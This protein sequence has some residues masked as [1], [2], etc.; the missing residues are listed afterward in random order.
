MSRVSVR[1]WCAAVGCGLLIV[2]AGAWAQEKIKITRLDE[3]PQHT[4]PVQGTVSEL[5]S[6]REAVLGLGEK[7]RADIEADLA[8]YEINDAATLQNLY[9]RL[10]NVELLNGQYDRALLRIEQ[11]RGLED[12]EAAKLTT[13]LTTLAMIEA[14]RAADPQTDFAAY[15]QA[16]KKN[17]AAR[18]AKLPY[19]IVQDELQET[20]GRMEIFSENF[21][22]GIVKAQM[23]PVVAKTGELSADMAGSVLG[24]HYLLTER[25]PV[26]DEIVAVLQA[27]ID[28]HKIEK[29]DI[30]AA[31]DVVLT[32][33]DKAQ[34]VLV[35]VWDSGVDP[36]IFKDQL[37]VNPKEQ[38][39]GQDDDANGFID[40]VHGVA[41]DMHAQRTTGEL[42]DLGAAAARMDQAMRH[43]KG[44][45]DVQAAVDS[46]EAA[47]LKTH[48]GGLKPEDVQRFIE[49][50]SLAG[51]YAH[52]THVAGIMVAGNPFARILI[53]RHTY[54]H[55][56]IPVVRTTEWGERDAGKCRD[57]VAYF[58]THGVRVVNMSWGEAQADAEDSYEKNGVGASAEERRELARKVFALQKTGLYEAMKNAPDILFI[59]AAGNEDSDV[60]FDE[61][62]PSSFELPN[63]LVVGAVDQAGDPT[64]FTSFGRTVAVYANG[65]EVDSYVPGGQRMKMS[66]TSMASPNVAN[67]A[68]KLL[69][70]D[71]TLKPAEVSALIKQ[72]A[73]KKP[74]GTQEILLINPQKSVALLKERLAKR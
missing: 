59:C 40:D 13:G 39:N 64:G 28:A 18:V 52:G 26:K 61:F 2:T 27:T 10:L 19:D 15:R 30:W 47:A 32:K 22:H 5:V 54:D 29:P 24:L 7:V 55:R 9:G 49:D 17:L 43:M 66:G 71:P 63:L 6:S 31:R 50:L 3:L 12:K 65:F 67:L 56:T 33:Q 16:F 8:K 44:F 51:H 42:Q 1:W 21:I 25:L 4:Y 48:L 20:K 35:A 37:W 36:K 72:G 53:G 58:K 45:M 73:E 23:E 14:R 74:A 38:P 62:I 70:L 69:A 68:A 46:P 11:I 41:Y 60:E 34:P 57:T